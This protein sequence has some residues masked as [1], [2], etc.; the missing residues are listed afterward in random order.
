MLTWS[1]ATYTNSSFHSGNFLCQ[2]RGWILRGLKGWF[3]FDRWRGL[4]GLGDSRTAVG[5]SPIAKQLTNQTLLIAF[6]VGGGNYFQ[7]DNW[8]MH[9]LTEHFLGS[10]RVMERER[11]RE[12]GAE[13]DTVEKK[14]CS[15]S[16][17]GF[18]QSKCITYSSDLPLKQMVSLITI[19]WCV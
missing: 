14:I 7:A 17:W 16:G 1:R 6:S 5:T 3:G 9:C 18:K 10:G 8:G 11:E 13:K 19:T 15:T 2:S 4:F 12:R